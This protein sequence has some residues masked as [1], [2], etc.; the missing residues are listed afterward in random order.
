MRTA[1]A[2]LADLV[3]RESGIVIHEQQHQ[4]L[5]AAAGRAAPGMDPSGLLSVL[6]GGPQSRV[7]L[8]RLIEEVT[9][10]E[11]FFFRHTSELLKLD[12]PGLAGRARTAGAETARVWVAG[13]ATGEEAYTLAMLSSEAFA[14]MSAPVSIVGTDISAPALAAARLGV[15]GRR[16]TRGIEPELQTRYL[17]AAGDKMVVTAKLRHMVSYA[18]H[19]LVRDPPPPPGSFDLITCRNVLIYF[20]PATAQRVVERLQRALNPGG[21]LL[22][23]AADRI[24][25][26]RA[27]Q[28]WLPDAVSCR[29]PKSRIQ[30]RASRRTRPP[31]SRA[32]IVVSEALTPDLA[33]APGEAAT[34]GIR[35]ALAAANAGRLSEAI[36]LIVEVLKSEPFNPEAHCVRGMAELGAGDA[37]AATSSLRQAL[38]VRPDFPLAAF[39]LGRALEAAGD[40]VAAAQAYR[41]AL[42]ALDR[43]EAQPMTDV[44][45]AAATDI[46]TACRLRLHVL[47]DNEPGTRRPGSDGAAPR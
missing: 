45:P 12:W 43:H 38:Y 25:T 33:T 46:A 19:N 5:A 40:P 9:V 24:S 6:D 16:A 36:E 20:D 11:T 14:P 8:R 35:A 42:R 29:L 31:E 23:G 39:K 47:G 1:L 17:M 15:Y 10:H 37:H 28:V 26:P 34:P 30:R 44:D 18:R 13:C 3:A 27:G 4:S 41:Q 7:A 22:L 32:A 2:Q 21:I